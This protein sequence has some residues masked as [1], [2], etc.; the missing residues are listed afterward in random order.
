MKKQS[1]KGRFKKLAGIHQKSLKEQTDYTDPDL[2]P[3]VDGSP[4]FYIDPENP[5]ANGVF[6][7]QGGNWGS[8]EDKIY[9][10]NL[11]V[12]TTGGGMAFFN[13]I[14]AMGPAYWNTNFGNFFYRRNAVGSDPVPYYEETAAE[15]GIIMGACSWTPEGGSGLRVS[16]SL[17]LS[18]WYLD[19]QNLD[20]PE[21]WDSYYD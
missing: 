9:L 1:L 11:D 19:G 14:F 7:V 2:L 10:G 13:A 8:C 3:F 18:N 16:T 5:G 15:N 17:T 6:F 20:A 21:L 12:I 4:Q